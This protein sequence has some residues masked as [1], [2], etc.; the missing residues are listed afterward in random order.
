[1]G[2]K[3]GKIKTERT[4][5]ATIDEQVDAPIISTT[6]T[7]D[8]TIYDDITSIENWV[9][10]G[11]NIC[12]DYLQVRDRLLVELN[13]ISWSGLTNN[14]KDI[15]IE[16]YLRETSK[17]EV[18][19]N[20]DKVTYL[21]TEKGYSQLQA[22]GTLIQSYSAY[23]LNE[24]NS[25]AKR[26]NSEQLYIV[27]AK[28]LTIIDAADLIKITHTLFD[29]YKS[30]AIR[31]TDDGSAGEGLFNFLES[32]VGSSYET[33]GL[34]QQGYTLNTGDYTSF[35]SELMNVLRNGNY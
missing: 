10:Y 6:G 17:D 1:M 14:E 23:H 28:H 32:T 8:T 3:I 9:Q 24:I 4:T 7:L 19:M 5:I 33:T 29:L 18:T 30:Q 16:Y 2:Y 21:M 25:C 27:I 15:V 34:E 20:T 35:V 12:T 11:K 26:G 22:Q 13:N 31:G